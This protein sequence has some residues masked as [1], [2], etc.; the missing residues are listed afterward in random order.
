MSSAKHNRNGLLTSTHVFMRTFCSNCSI[1]ERSHDCEAEENTS[2]LYMKNP[3]WFPGFKAAM[4]NDG[5]EER[6]GGDKKQSTRRK[7]SVMRMPGQHVY[8]CRLAN[9]IRAGSTSTLWAAESGLL[10]WRAIMPAKREQLH[11]LPNNIVISAELLHSEWQ[12][13]SLF[14][15]V[16]NVARFYKTCSVMHC[17]AFTFKINHNSFNFF[18]NKQKISEAQKLKWI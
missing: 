5:M 6:K 11:V 7:R 17:N 10:S 16:W 1:W 3:L 8:A 14:L 9:I 12:P 13:Q 18:P 4:Q 15:S 2:P